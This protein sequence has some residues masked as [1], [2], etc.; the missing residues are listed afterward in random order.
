MAAVLSAALVAA[1]PAAGPSS[2][3]RSFDDLDRLYREGRFF[4]LR[5][6]VAGRSGIASPSLDFYRGAVDLA[7]NRVESGIARLLK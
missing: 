5:D 2:R 7:F 4:E 3:E 6:A 1:A